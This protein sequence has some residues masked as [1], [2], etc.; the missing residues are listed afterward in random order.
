MVQLFEELKRRNVI[1]VAIAYVV[2]AWLII[3]VV[4]T[5]FPIYGL[6]DAAVRFVV[7]ALAVGFIPALF[8]A[9]A[10]EI[11]PEG[12]RWEKDVD[13]SQSV[14]PQTGKTLD[15]IIIGVLAVAVAFFAFDKF[16]LSES[17]EAEIAESAR[18]EGRTEALIGSYGD[19]SIAVLP[20]VDMS[21]DKDQEYMSDRHRRG[22][23]EP[24]CTHKRASR[25]I[26]IIGVFVQG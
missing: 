11:T 5:L 7:S 14:T 20:F 3:Q 24:A 10:L 17:R 19:R 13:R 15:R 4:E 6:S 16:V 25:H 1:R 12:L 2:T 9:W 23:T 8:L 18:E 21:P 22:T 26:E